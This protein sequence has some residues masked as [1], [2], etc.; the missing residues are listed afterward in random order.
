[1]TNRYIGIYEVD[2]NNKVVS[3]KLI[4]LTAGDIKVPA[5]V[6][7][8]TLPA[9]PLPGTNLNTTKV[10]TSVGAGNHLVTKV[11]SSLIP[12]PNVGDAAPTGA[13]VTN[14]Y[15]PGEDITG[16][17]ATTNKYIGVYEV[18]S[19]NKVVAFKLIILTADDIK[20]P[21]P[22]QYV[23]DLLIYPS[24]ELLQV[25]ASQALVTTAVYSDQS[26]LDVTDK[27]IYSTTDPSVATVDDSGIVTAISEGTTVITVQYDGKSV[28]A[29]FTVQAG[30]PDIRLDLTASPASV[31]GDGQSIVTLKASAIRL[32]DGNPVEGKT[33]TFQG[34]GNTTQTA[35]TDA[36]GTA[37]VTFT[38]PAI[39]GVLPVH[40]TITASAVDSTGLM[41]QTSI[42]VHYMPAS[43]HGVL[44][45]NTTGKPIAGAIVSVSTDFNGDGIVD[46]SQEVT[47]GADGSYQIYVPRGNWNYSMNIQTP[48]TIG[49][50][51]VMLNKT[52]TAQVG[53]LNGTE[54]IF[55]AANN[56]SGQ[57]LIAQTAAE[58]GNPQPT[59]D[60]LFGAGNV[61]AIVQG[62]GANNFKSQV[63]LDANGS[64]DV[65]NVPQGQY[66]VAYQIKASDGTILAGPTVTVNVNQ[67]GEM[68][69]V[70]SLIDPY[71]VVKDAVTGQ[72]VS[73]VSMNLY[74]AD[75][76]LNKQ[77]G[78]T[79]NTLVAL[80]ELPSF[81]PN[82]NHNPQ[83]TDAAGEYAWMVFPDGDY[84]I[85]ATKPG[86]GTF[87]TLTEQTSVTPDPGSDSY[88]QNGII[89]V[90]QSLVQFSFSMQPV[91]ESNSGSGNSGSTDSG[92]ARNNAPGDL[93]T[94]NGTQT[95]VTL[96]WTPVTGASS[97]NIYDNGKLIAS[98]ITGT[99]YE[100]TGLEAGTKHSFTV[101]AIVGGVESKLSESLTFTTLGIPV[102]PSAPQDSQH[103][104]KYINGYPDGT[105]KPAKNITRQEVAALLFRVFHL[106]KS[107][108]DGTAYS[109]VSSS[110]WGAEEIA[111][112]TKA[113]IMNGYPDGTFRPN[114]LI[115]REEMAGIAARLKQ[116]QGKGENSF[117]DISG[118]WARE[119][120]NSATEAGILKG[121]EDGTFRPKKNMTRAEAVTMINRLTS[122]GPLAGVVIPS[123]SDVSPSHWAYGDIEE[124]SVDHDYIIQDGTE[125]RVEQE[126]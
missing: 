114:Q 73:G 37:V 97:Y 33:I 27:A 96:S 106:A 38:A 121:Y 24:N 54:Q 58:N 65:N 39:S 115:T 66:I 44:T 123:W 120:I 30:I 71:G 7:A 72:P 84:Y 112:V 45:D 3:F 42:A 81:A 70:Y 2:S 61:S 93:K 23:V 64:F 125:R 78:R 29:V 16:V 21:A 9:S 19:N 101:S 48:V 75:T 108:T 51:T 14:P 55:T 46:F 63:V 68:S 118:S 59:I 17:D 90:G 35:V 113:G 102:N 100:I 119:S 15:T 117:K 56:I 76:E 26:I 79:P 31:V 109:D 98:G 10:T 94:S 25:G 69:V 4:I 91:K 74:W 43:V 34:I 6:T 8:P 83:V 50:Q 40:N 126:K 80:P 57:L 1:T 60:S 105:F 85:V 104:E 12:T 49:N 52:Q 111:A 36:T 110:D 67:N 53:T 20:V 28:S 62:A 107:E 92:N 89:H 82:Q 41:A 95:G 86:Y 32:V 77:K 87:N 47:T 124:A 88:I 99:R 13:G 122:R 116:L 22:T 18:D 5:P 11:S 103:H